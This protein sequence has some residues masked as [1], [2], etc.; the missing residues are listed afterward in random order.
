[1]TE[2]VTQTLSESG[3]LTI[4]MNRPEVLNSLNRPIVEA[5]ITAFNAA[6][7]N[8][9]VRCVIFTGSGRGFCAGAD[10]ANG[11]WPREDGWTPGDVTWHSM[12][13]GYNVLGRALVNCDKPVICAVNGIAA[14]AGV[15]L[16]L[17]ADLTIAAKSASFKLVFGP[18]LGIIPDVGASWHVPQLVGRARANGLAMLG[19][20]L[21]AEKAEQW[22]M[23]W[24]VVEDGNLMDAAM[25][26]GERMAASAITGLKAV[27]RAHDKAMENSLDAQLD[28]ERDMQ[29]H[30]CN[31]PVFFEGVA[32]F[33]QKRK[34]NFRDIETAQIKAARENK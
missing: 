3:V 6:S 30:Y 28:Y 31:Q 29:G 17:S 4:C 25:A 20:N 23:I 8:D 2:I 21:P 15:G 26:Y 16:A 13:K 22:G 24:E 10:L 18:Q 5:L 11:E 33:I 9:D 14:G 1:M 32:A 19:D 7:E 12:E 27:S 34:P